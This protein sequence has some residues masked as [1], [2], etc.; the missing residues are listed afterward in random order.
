[1]KS[2][3]PLIA[4]TDES[5]WLAFYN[6]KKIYN[7]KHFIDISNDI[8][9]FKETTIQFLNSYP[10]FNSHLFIKGNE[11]VGTY[12]TFLLNKGLPEEKLD[13]KVFFLD[14]NI[15]EEFNA[16]IILL[17]KQNKSSIKKVKANI[18]NNNLQKIFQAQG[19]RNAN[20]SIWFHLKLENINKNLVD[21]ILQTNIPK[22]NNLTTELNKELKGNVI[23]EVSRLMTI[24]LNDMKR[25]DEHEVFNE[26][27]ERVQ[28]IVNSHKKSRSNLFHLL[29]RN[30]KQE[31]IGMC[32]TV[33]KKDNPTSVNQFMTGVLKEY[34]GLGLPTWMKAY[35]Y[36]YLQKNYPT[37][38]LIKTDCYADNTPM[39]H[40]NEKMGFKEANRTIEMIY[41][42]N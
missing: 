16:E 34:R 31:L 2:V 26:T 24:L 18:E 33:F 15:L 5:T 22:N 28:E 29:L 3:I 30:E 27:P 12:N 6:F 41:E 21:N 32:I 37:I 35:M 8:E 20:E 7:K 14:E 4:D 39:V 40:I 36:D 19:F 38:N 11:V 25:N 10:N 1:M 17:I 23:I 9:D 42:K 13:V